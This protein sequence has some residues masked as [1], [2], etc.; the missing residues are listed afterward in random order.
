MVP[1]SKHIVAFQNVHLQLNIFTR[2]LNLKSSW[3][4]FTSKIKQTKVI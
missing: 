4:H 3:K 1:I 2:M